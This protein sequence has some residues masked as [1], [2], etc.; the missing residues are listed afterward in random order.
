MCL[1]P[2]TPFGSFAAPDNEK[3]LLLT[4]QPLFITPVRSVLWC[5]HVPD[6]TGLSFSYGCSWG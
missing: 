4:Q 3:G 2:L 6:G 1:K 5:G